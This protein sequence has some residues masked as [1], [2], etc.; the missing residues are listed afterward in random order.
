[1]IREHSSFQARIL[2]L[3]KPLGPD[4][5]DFVSCIEVRRHKSGRTSYHLGSLSRIPATNCGRR[6][7]KEVLAKCGGA[8]FVERADR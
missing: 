8:E 4:K 1:M 3:K 2:H 5:L 7:A 6:R